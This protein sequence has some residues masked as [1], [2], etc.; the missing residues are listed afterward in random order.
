[1]DCVCVPFRGWTGKTKYLS[2]FERGMVVG[3]RRTGLSVKNC[4]AAGF[5]TLNSFPCVSRMVHHPK[6]IQTSWHNCGEALESTWASIPVECFDTLLSSVHQ[7]VNLQGIPNRSSNFS[8]EKPMISPVHWVGKVFLFWDHLLCLK[9]Q[10]LL[11]WRNGRSVA[12]LSVPTVPI[13]QL[14]TPCLQLLRPLPQ[15][16][17]ILAYLRF[18]RF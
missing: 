14:K 18:H 11:T 7:P 4:N 9:R 12:K 16:S 5:F 3:A 15:Q 17:L 8:V 13:R 10:T 6:D 1:M 2:A